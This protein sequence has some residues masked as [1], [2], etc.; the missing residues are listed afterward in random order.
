MPPSSGTKSAGGTLRPESGGTAGNPSYAAYDYQIDVTIWIALEIM[1]AKGLSNEI[2]IEPPSHEDAEAT[3][4]DPNLA[5]LGVSTATRDT[6]L[7]VQIKSRTTSPWTSKA[8]AD[9]LLGKEAAT[10][11]K[12]KA[13][14]PAPRVRP[15]DMLVADP[16]AKYLFI[17]NEG[18]ESGLRLHQN[19]ALL[20]FPDPRDLPP[21][22]RNA[23]TAAE[24]AAL[25]KRIGICDTI[26][27]EMLES[28]IFKLLDRHGNVPPQKLLKCLEDMRDA[29]RKRLGGEHGGRW[30]MA[31]LLANIID[32]G[33]SRLA[34]R[35][36]D[37]FVPPRSFLSIEQALRDTHAV[38]IVGP[39][40]TG[41]SLAAD[42][43]AAKLVRQSPAFL[44]RPV[45]DAGEANSA[46]TDPGP[47][48]IYLRDP[49][50]DS[51]PSIEAARWTSKLPG[52][53]RMADNAHKFL[54]TTRYD[55][56]KRSEPGEA[57]E[58]YTIAIEPE[59]YTA[60][61]RALI[62]DN[63][64][65]DLSGHAHALALAHRDVVLGR[66]RRPYEIERF[67]AALP[68][69][70]EESPRSVYE[71]L[72]ASSIEAI[73]SVIRD[74]TLG[75]GD[76]GVACAAVLWGLLR[77]SGSFDLA[78]LRRVLRI[79]RNTHGQKPH[80]EGFI[81]FLGAGRN[82][83]VVDHS[84]RLQHPR[85]EEGLRLALAT[86]RAE[87]E[88]VL[89]ALAETLLTIAGGA[90]GWASRGA[91]EIVRAASNLEAVEIEF[92]ASAQAGL[93][94]ALAARVTA[95]TGSGSFERAFAD[96]SQLA[97]PDF[98][99]RQFSEYL[100]R[101]PPRAKGAWPGQTWMPPE[102]S[103]EEIECFRKDPR[104]GSLLQTFIRGV[105]PFTDGDY[106]EDF[107]SFAGLFSHDLG[108]A[109]GAAVETLASLQSPGD[110]I[111]TIVAG[112]VAPGGPGYDFVIDT[113]IKA[114][115]EV[116]RWFE[117]Y[118]NNEQRRA[119]EHEVDAIS[120]DRI[121]EEPGERYYTADAGLK[122][123]ALSRLA[124]EGWDWLEGHKHGA[125]MVYALASAQSNARGNFSA[126]Y[127]Q[128]LLK[129][130]DDR[131]LPPVWS[132]IEKNW[133]DELRPELE[134]ALSRTDVGNKGLRTTLAKLSFTAWPPDGAD[135]LAGLIHR[136]TPARRLELVLDLDRASPND[137]DS[138]VAPA[139]VFADRLEETERAIAHILVEIDSETEI[140]R[141]MQ[142]RSPE[143]RQRIAALCPESPL[144]LAGILVCLAATG[145]GDILETARRLLAT[146]D[147]DDGMPAIIA[148]RIRGGDEE[149]VLIR[150]GLGH[151]RYHVRRAAMTYLVEKNDAEDRAALLKMAED[152]GADVRLAW[153][154]LM[155]CHKWSEAE[156][157]LV[158]LLSD[159]RDFSLDRYHGPSRG[160]PRYSVARA[161][162]RALAAFEALTEPSIDAL[163]ALRRSEDP[164]VF[165]AAVG[166]LAK[167][168]DPRVQVVLREALD[169]PGLH[170]DADHRVIAQ[171]AV[172]GFFDRAVDG[173][174]IEPAAIEK[175]R[176]VALTEPGWIAGPAL[177]A[178]GI[179]GDA[180]NELLYDELMAAAQ[181]ERAELLQI[182]AALVPLPF[183][184]HP[185]TDAI[186]ARVEAL[187]EDEASPEPDPDLVTWYET[188]GGT[189][190]A[191]LTGWVVAVCLKL[192]GSKQVKDPRAYRVPKV[193]PVM[194]MYS[195]SPDREEERG[196]DEGD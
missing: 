105:L 34:H 93:D 71:I 30:T 168:S 28:R 161:A 61:Q 58:S 72:D 112:A 38:I 170:D 33:G 116:D 189:D 69:E 147:E 87:T 139:R 134:A 59:D 82:L 118:A 184:N 67:L 94:A 1:L 164:F 153:A 135:L 177:V 14:G 127:L 173:L 192:D 132:L 152:P 187:Q 158:S 146:G 137:I 121:L 151:P 52:L 86:N 128:I 117:S 47:L 25:G 81:D 129:H 133:H 148:L 3:L 89:T 24:K 5:S 176:L 102:L 96:L 62:Y 111:G 36:H 172:W 131:A 100:M 22:C 106:E 78:D 66:V 75:W 180:I 9:V 91:V 83:R 85:V 10:K 125:A 21:Y 191:W 73:S 130:A 80:V 150:H 18:L 138:K 141:L 145:E 162:A 90:D 65:G 142:G 63:H 48:L 4:K 107:L 42:V 54:I 124:A 29:V 157:L 23:R 169:D 56:F 122:A 103:A 19:I 196:P 119:R 84:I 166:A 11:S 185:L 140:G 76:D 55:I 149:H 186:V 49:W 37:Q 79:L 51:A 109:F 190:V 92:A 12:G 167:R 64:V 44:E 174:A 45:L 15:L 155:G 6:R 95:P 17:T 181:T 43:L 165:C 126:P 120:A 77:S 27:M 123:V 178:L 163:I 60:D 188:L 101:L 194:T 74:Q 156:P 110:N 160:W 193:V 98:A 26:T 195:M 41:K 171:A 13:R 50:G 113:F 40:G 183:G 143:V 114:E 159:D 46:L 104:T 154:E 16:T 136:M 20:S 68:R 70:K 182:A 99:P 31:N 179:R 88:A 97:S 39:S 57:L 8:F 175:L 2:E 53:F 108:G 7:I 35:R 115:N 144:G 32:N